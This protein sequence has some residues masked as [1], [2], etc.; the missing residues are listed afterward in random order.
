MFDKEM[1]NLLIKKAKA[2]SFFLSKKIGNIKKILTLYIISIKGKSRGR[3]KSKQVLCL[4]YGGL[5]FFFFK[6]K[7][8]Q[9]ALILKNKKA[10]SSMGTCY[11]PHGRKGFFYF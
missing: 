6:K 3:G 7:N 4:F 2:F 11:T 8:I 5:Y 1:L 10:F 9:K